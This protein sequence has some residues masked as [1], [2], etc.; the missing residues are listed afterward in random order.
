M[1]H[2]R[3]II[4][5]NLSITLDFI[6]LA[7]MMVGILIDN[8][9]YFPF[10]YVTIL[11]ILYIL[12][13]L[14]DYIIL[15]DP[16][17]DC[18][19]QPQQQGNSAFSLTSLP[20]MPLEVTTSHGRSISISVVPCSDNHRTSISAEE[21]GDAFAPEP[22]TPS[23]TQATKTRASKHPHTP[24]PPSR[25]LLQL[26]PNIALTRSKSHESQLANR[27]EDPATTK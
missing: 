9:L 21:M 18:S 24:P 22:S 16:V 15:G 6:V 10:L 8:Y 20:S 17:P 14:F 5:F 3:I 1:V 4:K 25:K 19:S 13:V 12:F 26:L 23:V 7:T 27:I 11:S 2:P